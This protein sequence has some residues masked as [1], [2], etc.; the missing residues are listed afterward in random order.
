MP[1]DPT[2]H[3]ATH[4][5]EEISSHGA[6]PAGAE[7]AGDVPNNGNHRSGRSRRLV[8]RILAILIFSLVLM[9]ITR[10][11][12]NASTEFGQQQRALSRKIQTQREFIENLTDSDESESK[13]RRRAEQRLAGLQ[14]QQVRW[15]S[16]RWPLLLLGCG[17]YSM[18]MLPSWLFFHQ[19]LKRLGQTPTARCT[20][21]AFFI[22]HLGKY[23]PGKALVVVLRSTLVAGPH[24]TLGAGVVAV[25]VETLTLLAVGAALGGILLIIVS[26][27]PWLVA[28]AAGLACL[29]GI[30]TIPPLFRAV[31]ERLQ[32]KR[33]ASLE[34]SGINWSLMGCGWGLLLVEWFLFGGSLAA[35]LLAI[36]GV[37]TE[38]VLQP[39]TICLVT[40]TVSLALVLGFVSLV[41]GGAGIR[42]WVVTTALGSVVGIGP[43]RALVAA[44]LL[45]FVWLFSEL[46]FASGG[47]LIGRSF[48]DGITDS[49]G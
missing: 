21:R 38:V 33:N 12:R 16:I 7:L 23:V 45:R 10:T 48:D 47:Y 29:A 28:G 18:G 20:F 46:V 26:G 9:G 36:P 8:K 34:L 22:G 30:P 3:D 27:D 14:S 43:I 31:V 6:E 39:D 40:A 35:T 11:V 13:S 1:D 17:F 37:T 19:T 32:R 24:V 49:E 2:H 44:I 41:P 4:D 5:V 42:E 15:A 25:F